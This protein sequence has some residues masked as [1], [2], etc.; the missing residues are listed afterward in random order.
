MTAKTRK[1]KKK[2]DTS[3]ATWKFD[4]ENTVNADPRLGPACLK[5][6]RAYLD[7]M[8]DINAAPYLSL[9][10]LRALTALTEHTIIKARR[11]LV[12]EG[13]FKEAGKTSSG[14]I[15][16]QIVNAGKN[17]VLDHV[18]ITREVLKQFEADKKEERRRRAAGNEPCNLSTA[19]IA[20]LEPDLHCKIYRDSTAENA[21]NYVENTVEVISYEEEEPLSYH[22]HY[23]V[24]SLGDDATQPFPIPAN[25]D[26][27]ESLLDTICADV[28]RVESVRRTLKLFL[29]GGTLSPQRAV[30]I[31][32]NEARTAA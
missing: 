31:L 9:V 24:M 10:H 30:N 27:A 17:R 26:E 32:G 29:M 7:F 15:R 3:L 2:K 25:D 14:A 21:G 11:E 28:K 23:A 12:N 19:R 16:Y 5:I 20:G 6:V 4:L 18:T 22:N 1:P 13:Y 8:G